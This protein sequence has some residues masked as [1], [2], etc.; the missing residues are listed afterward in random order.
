M[1]SPPTVTGSIDDPEFRRRRA[2]H[3]A[4]SRT[5]VD[6][7]IEKLVAAAPPLTDEQKHRL[8]ALLRPT[9]RAA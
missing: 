4:K 3:A 1:S 5:S 6:H 7:Y 8:A 2:A 9:D